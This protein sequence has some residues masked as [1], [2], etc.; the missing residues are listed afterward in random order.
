MEA[1]LRISELCD[2]CSAPI[3]AGMDILAVERAENDALQW[4]RAVSTI[5]L[6]SPADP[7]FNWRAQM[8]DRFHAVVAPTIGFQQ[9][10]TAATEHTEES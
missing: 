2:E 1:G 5:Q 6:L 3:L 8:F 10:L 9:S 7:I 4:A